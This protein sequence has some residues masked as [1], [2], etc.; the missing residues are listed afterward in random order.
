M[1]RS[2]DFTAPEETG[3]DVTGA[4]DTAAAGTDPGGAA[5]PSTFSPA[6]CAAVALCFTAPLS[7]AMPSFTSFTASATAHPHTLGMCSQVRLL[8]MHANT[9]DFTRPPRRPA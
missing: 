5:E 4:G 2:A 9:P 3:A 6:A 8:F 7:V 1:V